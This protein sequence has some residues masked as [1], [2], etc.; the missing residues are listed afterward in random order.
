MAR[1][2]NPLAHKEFVE[3]ELDDM[4][5]ILAEEEAAF[6]K[7]GQK[8]IY[9]TLYYKDLFNNRPYTSSKFN[10]WKNKFSDITAIQEKLEKIKE[11]IE[12]RVV[13]CAARNKINSTFAIF[14]LK[15]Q[16]FWKDVQDTRG[17]VEHT[18]RVV[19]LPPEPKTMEEWSKGLKK[20]YN[21]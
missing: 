19:N 17:N 6:V 7:S 4:L 11:I 15:N 3:S 9:R 5:R 16:A 10:Y 18:H 13:Y 8:K 12:S 14:W 1:P 20:M 21:E 2:F